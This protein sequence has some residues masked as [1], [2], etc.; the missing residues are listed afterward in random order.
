MS[1][2]SDKTEIP[3]RGRGSSDNPE[4]RFEGYYTD[5]DLDE[6][7]G[8]KPSPETKFYSDHTKDIIATNQSPDIPFD[9]SINPY[10]GCEHGCVYCYA[11]PTHEYLGFSAGLDFES[12]IMVKRKAPQQLR[13]RLASPGWKPEVLVMSGVTD[14]YQPVE[15]ELELTRGCLRVLA[16]FLNPVGIITKN[17]MVTR[18]IDLLKE[19]A[20]HN[21]V[22]VTLS[23][24]TL[25]RELAR[26]MEPRTSRPTRRL[27]AIE[28]LAGQGIP[29]GVNVAPIIPGLTDHEC[30]NIL[31]AAANAGAS[32][33]GYTLLRL[34]HGV[35]ELFPKWLEQHFPERKEKV[36]NRVRDMRDGRLNEPRF[37]K[38]MK[39]QGN[40]AGQIR[41][42]FRVHAERYGLNEETLAL[43]TE[44]FRPGSGSQLGL[45][46]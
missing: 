14:P 12:R 5:Y 18:D 37:N 6:E 24:T 4:N 21:A 23:I 2:A 26:K 45:F 29:V 22:C 43:S 33:A 31:E 41:D 38:R 11:R 8:R 19:L 25:D 27:Q 20:D 46:S 16:E 13:K 42:M 39:G 32:Y 9:K 17:Y 44:A 1:K 30:P 15:R 34:P 10:R 40:Y 3:I 35:K 28:E 7:T 36:L